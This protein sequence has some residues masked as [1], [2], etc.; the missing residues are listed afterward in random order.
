MRIGPLRPNPHL[1]SRQEQVAEISRGLKALARELNIPV[2]VLAQLN[3]GPEN[4]SDQRPRMADL[5]ESGAVEQDAD[6]I[7]L[8]HREEY[9]HKADTQWMAVNAD[10]VGQA[11]VIIDKQR[12]G[13][14]GVVKLRWAAYSMRFENP[15]QSAAPAPAPVADQRESAPALPWSGTESSNEDDS[16][17]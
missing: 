12:N 10:K 15:E 5:R 6:V 13:P 14:T 7:L 2:V 16:P 1:N 17:F 11:E 3:R 4:R 8:L 9:Y